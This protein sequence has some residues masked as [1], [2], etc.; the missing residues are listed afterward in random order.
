MAHALRFER[1]IRGSAGC[2]PIAGLRGGRCKRRRGGLSVACPVAAL[3]KELEG[4]LR[5]TVRG[6]IRGLP[7]RGP[8]AGITSVRNSSAPA[9]Y[10]RSARPRPH[11]RQPYSRPASMMYGLSVACPA[12]A[13]LRGYG[14]ENPAP[15]QR[16]VHGLP[17]RSPI[18]ASHSQPPWCGDAVCP[19]PGRVAAPSRERSPTGASAEIGDCPRLARP[20]PY[21]GYWLPEGVSVELPP[22]AACQVAAPSQAPGRGP[23]AAHRALPAACP[24]AA[25]SQAES[26]AHSCSAHIHLPAFSP[27]AAPSQDL[28]N[29]DLE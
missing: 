2:G 7:G 24:A 19:Q 15:A 17:G 14:V 8:I 10:S 18:A 29:L 23:D 6:S 16:P 1:T 20:R 11:R 25:P 27:S 4:G 3:S 13:P 12:A 22:S 21:R 9:V 28:V 26:P 5:V